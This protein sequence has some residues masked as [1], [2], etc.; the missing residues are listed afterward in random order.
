MSPEWR[1]NLYRRFPALFRLHGE[2][3]SFVGVICDDGWYNIVVRMC[4]RLMTLSE[5]PDL[6]TVKQK[7]GLLRVYFGRCRTTDEARAIIDEAIAESRV[8]CE[9]CGAP[10]KSLYV[11]EIIQ[12]VCNDHQSLASRRAKRFIG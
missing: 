11:H 9:L 2:D 12:I 6:H 7:F 8:T 10:G 4:E 3:P 5:I 1:D